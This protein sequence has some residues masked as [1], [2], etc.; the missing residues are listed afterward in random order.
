M[1]TCNTR[2]NARPRSFEATKRGLRIDVDLLLPKSSQGSW[3]DPIT[4]AFGLLDCSTERDLFNRI[5]IPLSHLRSDEESILVRRTHASPRLWANH[6]SHDA[7]SATVH[8]IDSLPDFNDAGEEDSKER[9]VIS[10]LPQCSV[11]IPPIPFM[12]V[13]QLIVDPTLAITTPER[14]DYFCIREADAS[15]SRLAS[16]RAYFR[17]RP[18]NIDTSSA[19]P[20]SLIMIAFQFQS[21]DNIDTPPNVTQNGTFHNEPHYDH[22]SLELPYQPRPRKLRKKDMYLGQRISN[23]W[24]YTRY[25]L[26]HKKW[27]RGKINCFVVKTPAVSEGRLKTSEWLEALPW[28]E[29]ARVSDTNLNFKLKIRKVKIMGSFT[30]V[31]TLTSISDSKFEAWR[32]AVYLLRAQIPSQLLVRAGLFFLGFLFVLASSRGLVQLNWIPSSLWMTVGITYLT[33]ALIRPV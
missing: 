27:L 18:T 12:S 31:L 11:I 20:D 22:S 16:G 25:Y 5:A 3:F 23:R 26:R 19:V 30:N 14:A 28:T 10:A 4:E 32:K 7:F 24:S 8:V 6:L 29:A 9:G 2:R 21:P 15:S 33:N 17:L 1:V 13:E